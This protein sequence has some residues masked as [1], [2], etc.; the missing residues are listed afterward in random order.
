MGSTASKIS[1][2][3]LAMNETE[4]EIRTFECAEL[5]NNDKSFKERSFSSI[6]SQ[7]CFDSEF[8]QGQ[9]EKN[10]EY[11]LKENFNPLISKFILNNNFFKLDNASGYDMRRIR[12][13][14]FSLT[15]NKNVVTNNKTNPDKVNSIKMNLLFCFYELKFLKIN[16]IF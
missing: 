11:F 13:L 1:Y 12:L 7:I 16:E 14:L 15:F 9:N 8:F 5:L 2:M 3:S 6:Y 4:R 10:L